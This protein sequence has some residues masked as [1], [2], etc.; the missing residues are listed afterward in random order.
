MCNFS[1][2]VRGNGSIM[3][4]MIESVMQGECKVV[5]RDIMQ[6]SETLVP[7]ITFGKGFT[8]APFSRVKD[9]NGE[10]YP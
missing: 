6:L 5:D 4:S 1:G 3:K 7:L 10:L 2:E 9:K 8:P